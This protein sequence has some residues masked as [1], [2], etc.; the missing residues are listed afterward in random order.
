LLDDD[1]D[2]AEALPIRL[3]HLP[4]DRQEAA[5][6]LG[7][8]VE[9]LARF[10]GRL[11][12]LEERRRGLRRALK[13]VELRLQSRRAKLLA[14]ADAFSR[15]DEQQRMGEILVQHQRTLARG[16]TEATLPNP[17]GEAG[18]TLTIPLDPTLPPHAN[19]ERL[20]KA[21]RRARR[22]AGR[23]AARMAETDEALSRAASMRERLHA[24]SRRDELDA[25]QRTLEESRL[26]SPRELATLSG[27]ADLRRPVKAAAEASA[28]AGLSPR[29][30]VSSD[31]IPI[32]VGKNPEGNDYLTAHLARS[33]DLWLHVQG[34]GGSHVVV[35]SAGR[36]GG[37]PRR[38]LVQAA[39]L[40]AYYSQAR[41]EGKVAV[42]YTL[43][44]YV[45]KP[46]KTKPGLV[47]IS[48]EKT[49][50]VAPDK[51]LVGRLAHTGP[52]AD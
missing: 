46:R 32:L 35:R 27:G 26:L 22:G 9:R 4:P 45:R 43:K 50:I 1:G 15:A 41:D 14:D 18:A 17:A 5:P 39:Q 19:A 47:T 42:D 7:A 16:L 3:A 6:S 10:R 30:F 52:P 2:P 36:S 33:N 13:R 28:P 49:I 24:A 20:F 38:T 21:A 31:G 12:D 44:K 8:A 25:V 23:V 29:R 34:R 51:S 11:E 37:V 48:Q 40:A